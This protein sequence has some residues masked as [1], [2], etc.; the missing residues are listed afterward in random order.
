[1]GL[2][3]GV[4]AELL[5]VALLPFGLLTV[6]TLGMG[7]CTG[8]ALARLAPGPGLLGVSGPYVVR[9]VIFEE[10]LYPEGGMDR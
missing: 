6:F 4:A 8:P 9:R 1:V 10:V 3:V 7:R 5:W 2:L